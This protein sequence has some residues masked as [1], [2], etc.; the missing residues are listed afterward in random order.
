MKS[1]CLLLSLFPLFSFPLFAQQPIPVH[2]NAGSE[3]LP[4]NFTEIRKNAAVQTGELVNGYYYRYVQCAMVPAAADRAA[5]EQDGV[6]FVA[7]VPSGTYLVAIPEHFRLENFE[8]IQA[9]SVVPVRT[10]PLL[11]STVIAP[12]PPDV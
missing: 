6:V 9:R 7:Y 11:P 5:L 3:F 2:F 8:K 10:A 1:R 12:A 4:A